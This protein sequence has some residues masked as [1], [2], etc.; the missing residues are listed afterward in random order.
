MTTKEMAVKICEALSD[1][2][3]RDVLM[4][5][6]EHMTII[7]DYFVIASGNSVPQ[8][9]ALSDAVEECA[10]E[11]GLS[12]RRSAGY[13]EGRWVIQDFGDVV[14]HIFHQQEREFYD[15]ERLWTDGDNA[16]W[17]NED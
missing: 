17:F 5:A 8:V 15:L 11:M 4:L 12:P 2:K 6:V 16:T 1:K 10:Q 3:G 7:A 13:R 14:V 9:Q